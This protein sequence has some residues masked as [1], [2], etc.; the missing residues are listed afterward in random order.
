[1]LLEI[2]DKIWSG[3]KIFF[4]KIQCNSKKKTGFTKGTNFENGNF[5]QNSHTLC[6]NTTILCEL[7]QA[8]TPFQLETLGRITIE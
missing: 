8:H 5:F 2:R 6:T 3:P 1:M 4:I 7:D